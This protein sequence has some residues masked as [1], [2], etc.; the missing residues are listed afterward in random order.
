MIDAPAPTLPTG[1]I[2]PSVTSAPSGPPT[3]P[4]Q[5][6]TLRATEPTTVAPVG[7]DA[8]A[9]D[10]DGGSTAGWALGGAVALAAAL[11]V[12]FALVRRRRGTLAV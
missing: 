3:V 7:A 9:N 1:A 6:A 2:P 10:D 11:L 4:P 12:G 8:E 5:P